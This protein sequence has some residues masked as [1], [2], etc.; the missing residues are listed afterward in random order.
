MQ[1]G[2]TIFRGKNYS[3]VYIGGRDCCLV[4]GP[5]NAAHGQS[6]FTE[7]EAIE[8]ADYDLLSAYDKRRL[9]I[10]Q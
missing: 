8:A 5:R 1:Y 9:A 3:V 2:D 6:F 10:I 7:D 4:V